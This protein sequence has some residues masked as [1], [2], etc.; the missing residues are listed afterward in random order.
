MSRLKDF[1]ESVSGIPIDVNRNMRLMRELDY[2][3]AKTKEK[4]ENLQNSY[5]INSRGKDKKKD[6][7]LEEIKEL[8]NACL[9]LSKEKVDLANQTE[10]ILESSLKKLDDEIEKV[11]KLF[12]DAHFESLDT[13]HLEPKQ[14][15]VQRNRFNRGS[16][17]RNRYDNLGYEAPLAP[18]ID[19]KEKFCYC[20]GP[21]LGTMI[22]CE[23]EQCPYKWFHLE[24]V[25]ITQVPGENEVW[26]CKSCTNTKRKR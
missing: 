18:I 14:S 24:C 25:G 23:N 16:S 1:L 11:K 8:Q 2:K 15:R 3:F 12:P 5:L 22:C 7:T 17:S 10:E 9:E 6:S 21:S 19:D 26:F 4:L 13:S 20:R